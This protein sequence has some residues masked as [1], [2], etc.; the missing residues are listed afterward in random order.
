MAITHGGYASVLLDTCMGGAIHTELKP[1]QSV[2]RVIH[3]GCQ[4]RM[5]ERRLFDAAGKLLAHGTTT[6]HIVQ[7]PE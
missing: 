5:S 3:L 2:S 1:G 6:C 4:A 7:I